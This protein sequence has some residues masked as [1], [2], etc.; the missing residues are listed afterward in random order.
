M[1]GQDILLLLKL[2]SLNLKEKKYDAMADEK[3]ATRLASSE[4]VSAFFVGGAW[5]DWDLDLPSEEDTLGKNFA[6]T[7]TGDKTILGDESRSFGNRI[8][9]QSFSHSERMAARDEERLSGLGEKWW[10][11]DEYSIRALEASTGISKSQVSVS[12]LRCYQNGLAYPDI[13]F[14]VPRVNMVALYEFL[15]YGLRY[16]FPA[17]R[18]QVTRGISTAWAAPVLAESIFSGGEL[19]FV[20]PDVRG[21]AKGIMLEPIYKTVPRAVRQDECLYALLALVDSIRVGQA[22]EKTAAIKLLK[23]RMELEDGR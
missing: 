19:P 17:E 1:K 14:D 18:G 13:V 4:F 23:E 11:H 3:L 2:V 6:F 9:M 5:Q 22:R 12:L 10:I 21:K 7:M 20:W 16:V 15:V 8:P